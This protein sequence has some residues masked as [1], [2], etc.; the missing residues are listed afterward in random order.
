[1]DG[2]HDLSLIRRGSVADLELVFSIQREASI[3][4]FANVFP[5]DRYPYPDD[6]V[7]RALREQLEDSGN[8]V[9]LDREGRGFA[10]VGQGWLQQLF[11][12]EPAWG[13]GVADELHAAALDT[14]GSQGATSASLWCLAEN[15]RARR[16]YEKR[17]WRLNG[18]ERV[19]P[20]P[21]HPL[22]VGYS[23]DLVWGDL[24]RPAATRDQRGG[25]GPT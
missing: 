23:I 5:P 16:F 15:A 11:V 18:S 10:L 19:V 22:D 24:K 25:G 9:L 7:R 4:A 12:R 20:F 1:V 3:A 8:V 6:A 14:L 21:P 17:G 13:T 2:A